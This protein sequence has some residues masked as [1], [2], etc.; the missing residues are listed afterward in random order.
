MSFLNS[1]RL[2]W[3]WDYALRRMC[4]WFRGMSV[5]GVVVLLGA[6]LEESMSPWTA[7]IGSM[8]SEA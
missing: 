7:A 6:G 3:D 4:G 5:S 2:E 8:L 1:Y